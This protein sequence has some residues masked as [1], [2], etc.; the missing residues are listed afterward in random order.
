MYVFDL[1]ATEE[2]SSIA[3]TGDR[4]STL[5]PHE[6]LEATAESLPRRG[7]E[8]EVRRL[9]NDLDALAARNQKPAN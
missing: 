2:R 6:D 3:R 7:R 8:H 1:N 4:G 9:I 5:A